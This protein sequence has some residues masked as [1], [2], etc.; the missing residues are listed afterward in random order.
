METGERSAFSTWRAR[1]ATGLRAGCFGA[2]LLALRWSLPSVH[3]RAEGCRFG[4]PQPPPHTDQLWLFVVGVGLGNAV[5]LGTLVADASVTSPR[6]MAG[7]LV[8][9]VASIGLVFAAF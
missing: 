5:L 4:E 1:I 2:W 8:A 3:A 9:T 7:W 6:R